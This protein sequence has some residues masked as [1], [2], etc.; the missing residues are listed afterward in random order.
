MS[1]A[2]SPRALVAGGSGGLGAACVEALARTG[3]SVTLTC[4]RRLE[5][6][7]R[8]AE[9]VQG[10]AVQVAFPAPEPTLRQL[11]E[12]ASGGPGGSLEALVWAVGPEVPQEPLSALEPAALARALS[13]EVEAF[14]GL[15]RAALPALRR[16]S[17]SV[18]A[19]TSAGGSRFP[20]G[21][22]LSVVPKGA[23]EAL[24]RGLAREEGKHGLRAN[25]VAVG[26][27][28]AGMFQRLD[29]PEGWTEAALRR[30]PLRRLG[31]PEEVGVTVA[32]L[33]SRAA[34]YI[35]GNVLRVD[36]GYGV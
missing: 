2:P 35:T 12:L 27:V 5:A 7:Q 32:F 23:V 4:H 8:L 28:D 6:G 14:H 3:F 17:G 20:P 26:V 11:V 19:L 16:G 1:D 15:L 29:L 13:V 9:Q 34:G 25:A 21:D 24:I 31:R 33:C 36:G 30:I 22:A 18:V 10:C